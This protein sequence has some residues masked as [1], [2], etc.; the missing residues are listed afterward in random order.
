[1]EKDSQRV[2]V[3]VVGQDKVG[4]GQ[5]SGILTNCVNILILVRL[6]FRIFTMIMIVDISQAKVD[7]QQLQNLLKEKGEQIGVK[8]NA[9][10]E[11][12]LNLC[13]SLGGRKDANNFMP[14]EIMET[15]HMVQVDN[16]FAP[17]R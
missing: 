8:I 10:H 1:M 12:S 17:L 7:L 4:I 13:I 11:I 5:V 6:F 3:T 2:I 15:M 16:L 14:E 9:Q